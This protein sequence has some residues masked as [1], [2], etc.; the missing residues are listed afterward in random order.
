MKNNESDSREKIIKA[1][2]KVL[3]RD[4]YDKASTKEIAKEA[5]VAQGLVNYYF[6]KK[7]YLFV[8]VMKKE[9]ERYCENMVEY[10]S[11]SGDDIFTES[12][13]KFK[14]ELKNNP[15]LYRLRYELFAL[16]MRN[17]DVLDEVR[18]FLLEKGTANVSLLLKK[19]ASER[20]IEIPNLE[21][22]SVI[23]FACVDGLALRGFLDPDFD[24]IA[25]H[26]LLIDMIKRYIGITN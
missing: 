4:G 10:V 20:N 1:A 15:E 9:A 22:L 18:S 13:K 3:A 8:E 2:Y 19:I 25:A 17:P 14:H 23:L 7:D 5:G 21:N 24:M 26:E 6:S 11:L 12:V 16:G